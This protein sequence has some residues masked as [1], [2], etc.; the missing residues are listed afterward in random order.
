MFIQAVVHPKPVKG[1]AKGTVKM[2]CLAMLHDLA[3]M[4]SLRLFHLE[5]LYDHDPADLEMRFSFG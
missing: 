1:L 3:T 2:N 5:D 4:A